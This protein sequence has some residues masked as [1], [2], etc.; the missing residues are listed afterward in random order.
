MDIENMEE[1]SE[2]FTTGGISK[3]TDE[4]NDLDSSSPKLLTTEDLQDRD[5]NA[6]AY[7]KSMLDTGDTIVVI[8]YPGNSQCFDSTGF[9]LVNKYLVNSAKLLATGPSKFER[10]FQPTEQFRHQRRAGY[11]QTSDI[12]KGV[13]YFLDLTPPE[14]GDEA[15]E[16]TSE[17]SCSPGIRHWFTAEQ[18]C[19]VAHGLVG[20]KDEVSQATLSNPRGGESSNEKPHDKDHATATPPQSS[21]SSSAWNNGQDDD[22]A[23][24]RA[25]EESKRD[26]RRHSKSSQSADPKA[27]GSHQKAGDVLDYCPIRHRAGIERLLQVIEGKDPRLDSAPKVWTLFALAKFFEC[28]SVVV[29]YIVTWMIV[30]PNCQ[31]IEILPEMSCK[32]GMGL[33]NATITRP[34]FAILVSEE[35]L[36]LASRSLNHHEAD[37]GRTNQFLRAREYVDEDLQTRIEYASKAFADKV[38]TV[39]AELIDDRLLWFLQLPEYKKICRFEDDIVKSGSGDWR[40]WKS[41]VSRLVAEL[42]HFVRGR[43]LWCIAAELPA[44]E[45]TI[46][47]KHR[48]AEQ[49]L[50]PYPFNFKDI[51]SA[52][53]GEERIMTTFFWKILRNVAFDTNCFSNLLLDVDPT[54][55]LADRNGVKKV[56]MANLQQSQKLLNSSVLEAIQKNCFASGQL[57]EEALPVLPLPDSPTS[58]TV[59]QRRL[60]S[61]TRSSVAADSVN[62][63]FTSSYN[64]DHAYHQSRLVAMKKGDICQ[65]A[66]PTWLDLEKDRVVSDFPTAADDPSF[67]SEDGPSEKRP[68]ALAMPI[69]SKTPNNWWE[70][71][72]S[73]ENE[74]PLPRLKSYATAA[75]DLLRGQTSKSPPQHASTKSV[76]SSSGGNILGKVAELNKSTYHEAEPRV[77]LE[78]FM[79]EDSPFFNLSQF[80]KQVEEHVHIICHEMLNIREVEFATLTDTLLCLDEDQF[81]YLPLWAGGNDDGSGGVFDLMIPATDAGPNGPGPSFHTGWSTNSA[82][83]TEVNFDGSS[84][85]ASV[86]TSIGVENGFID[87]LDRRHIQSDDDIHSEGFSDDSEVYVGKGKGRAIDCSFTPSSVSSFDTMG[88]Y[89]TSFDGQSYAGTEQDGTSKNPFESIYD[90]SA[91]NSSINI[92]T[93][94]DDDADTTIGQAND[95]EEEWDASEEEE[96][97]EFGDSDDEGDTIIV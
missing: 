76:D 82:A 60:P 18:R 19:D 80:L 40:K 2:A 32:I 55:P 51:Y 7:S 13:K 42:R 63:A 72:E 64:P 85:G 62:Y 33:Q 54:N 96:A 34:A 86:N 57:P 69:R 27:K 17:L 87:H 73:G 8:R 90:S 97:F 38:H 21:D 20:G 67:V 81:K 35:A 36:S 6:I 16:L 37:K 43:I 71:V 75:T 23:L 65:P 30:E 15:L 68:F 70:P 5:R 50:R 39:V 1:I 45:N 93:D 94:G 29:D 95:E 24:K 3:V 46:A 58:N 12:P 9:P 28:T 92:V 88:D 48:R 77:P 83:T 22:T 41:T 31:F 47:N 84:R 52:L 89:Q 49:Y 10:Y 74:A 78:V 91:N 56:L 61:D 11:G 26:Y 59:T 79:L 66:R 44:V 53:A 14:E 25:I 4:W